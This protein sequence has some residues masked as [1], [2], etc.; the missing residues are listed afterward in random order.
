VARSASED[1]CGGRKREWNFLQM[2]A[3]QLNQTLS[4]LSRRRPVFHSEADFQHELA[5]ELSRAGHPV[6]LEVPHRVQINDHPIDVEVDVLV[7]TGNAWTAI[8][9][10]YVK[11][12]ATIVHG[13]ETFTL[14][15]TW[16]TNLPRF[17]CLADLRRVECL[18]AAGH[19]TRGFSVFLTYASDAWS[20]DV[21]VSEIKSRNFSLHE[22]RLLAAG[23]ALDW[24]GNEPTRASVTA[25]RLPPHTP[26]VP[27]RDYQLGW[28]DYSE[29]AHPRG[30]FRYL[31]LAGHD[32]GDAA[33]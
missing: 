22:R 30:R 21:S 24:H 7:R 28:R 2:N 4:N 14:A 16:G 25:K 27:R 10:K 17:D 13:G 11:R 23:E 3:E 1:E 6:R 19:V 29:L 20:K 32:D 26:I 5:L 9:L 8:E 31:L 15:H 18:V 12:A 33:A